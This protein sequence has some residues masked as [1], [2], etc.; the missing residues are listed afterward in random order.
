[1][2]RGEGESSGAPHSQPGRAPGNYVEQANSEQM[3]RS[4]GTSRKKIHSVLGQP[5]FGL[6]SAMSNGRTELLHAVHNKEWH[7]ERAQ[8]AQRAQ[9]PPQRWIGFKEPSFPSWW[10]C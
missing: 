7:I 9:R 6:G 5:P 4:A 10:E 2:E 3:S 8:R 1:M